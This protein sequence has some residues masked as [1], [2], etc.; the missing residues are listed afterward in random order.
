MV[1]DWEE[2]QIKYELFFDTPFKVV[3]VEGVVK[4]KTIDRQ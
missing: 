2:N 3:S 4:A 1:V